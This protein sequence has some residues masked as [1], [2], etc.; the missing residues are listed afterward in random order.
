MAYSQKRY[1]KFM[2]VYFLR[3]AASATPAVCAAARPPRPASAGAQ[4]PAEHTRASRPPRPSLT[5]PSAL[6]PRLATPRPARQLH[7]APGRHSTLSHLNTGTHTGFSSTQR[8]RLRP[9]GPQTGYV[10]PLRMRK[11]PSPTHAVLWVQD[12]PFWAANRRA[13]G[14]TAALAGLCRVSA[15]E[16]QTRSFFKGQKN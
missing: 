11:A 4:G 15:R 7:A 12:C 5:T 2:P 8:E 16:P 9:Q 10:K 6:S 13:R 3:C 1:S 14:G